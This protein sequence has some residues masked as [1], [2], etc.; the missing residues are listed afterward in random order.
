MPVINQR[1]CQPCTACCEGWLDIQTPVVQAHLGKACSH[2]KS[3][4]CAIYEDRPQNPCQSFH[5]AWRQEGS[6]LP[7][8][9]RPD[10][11]GVIVMTDKLQWEGE[12]VIMAVAAGS[13]IPARTFHWLCSLAQ[14][15]ARKLVAVEYQPNAGG[16]N[17]EFNMHTNG[18]ED[19]RQVMVTYFA[20]QGFVSTFTTAHPF[21]LAH[22]QAN[23]ST[24]VES[25]KT[26]A[27]RWT[28]LVSKLPHLSA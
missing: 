3:E 5:C 6:L 12:D 19:F 9:M 7:H 28:K 26:P 14:L 8:A 23:V 22:L 25:P 18:S 1:N 20:Q 13:R 16:F 10:L 21:D 17:G 27:P 24:K 2:C 11:S 4:G 15:T